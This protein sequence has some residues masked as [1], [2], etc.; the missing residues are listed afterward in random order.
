MKLGRVYSGVNETDTLTDRLATFAKKNVARQHMWYDRYTR[1]GTGYTRPQDMA[2]Q[3]R[4]YLACHSI[5]S[6]LKEREEEGFA[7]FQRGDF[8]IFVPNSCATD[9]EKNNFSFPYKDLH[10]TL[11]MDIHNC[12]EVYSTEPAVAWR[13]EWFDYILSTPSLVKCPDWIAEHPE[14]SKPGITPAIMTD[15]KNFPSP[16]SSYED[17]NTPES[18]PA[19]NE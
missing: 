6:L 13:G 7:A 1:V 16:P 12:I 18:P 19:P 17:N 15:Y 2:P 5:T 8:L 3:G 9:F 14:L 4:R 11:G 10:E